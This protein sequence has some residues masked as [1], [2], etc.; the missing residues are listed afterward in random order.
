MKKKALIIYGWIIFSIVCQ[1]FIYTLIDKVYLK[2]RDNL[3]GNLNMKTVDTV[4]TESEKKISVDIPSAAKDIKVSY[5]GSYVAYVL[6]NK[7]NIIDVNT[8]ETKK[9][10]DNYFLNKDNTV[11]KTE[12]KFTAFKWVPYKNMIMFAM[13]S[14]P[15]TATRGQIYTYD[16][17]TG[18]IHVSKNIL[19]ENYIP[20]GS[21]ISDIIIS[22]FT[23][24][25]Y[26]K[27]SSGQTNDR[28]YRVDI[29]D[30]I[31]TSVNL[32]SSETVKVGFYTEDLYYT[33]GEQKIMIKSG[34]K[35]PVSIQMPSGQVLLGIGGTSKDAKDIIY[36]GELDSDGKLKKVLYGNPST[37]VSEWKSFDLSKPLPKD[38]FVVRDE[39][40]VFSI[41][42]SSVTELS[43]GKTTSFE[44]QF[45]NVTDTQVVYL[46]NGKLY[47]K[48]IK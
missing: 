34:L 3:A 20:R 44:G 27:V 30:E 11:T 6:D 7:L 28:F 23:M 14:L 15:N 33:Q 40:K 43:S 22:P 26:I 12:S 24:V 39:G 45:I 35:S 37:N 1:V 9:V 2:N 38:S 46:E 16:L 42:G 8:Q 18:N 47:F 17:E 48:T 19:Y 4:V 32:P 36:S 29:M 10:I 5:D 21:E 13:N 41:S 31:Y 25:Y